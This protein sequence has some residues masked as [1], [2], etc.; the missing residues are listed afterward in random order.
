MTPALTCDVTPY[1][2]CRNTY[3]PSHDTYA[4]LP[5]KRERGVGGGVQAE[6][7]GRKK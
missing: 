4:S 2:T 5:V 7:E 1:D 6:T 3:Q